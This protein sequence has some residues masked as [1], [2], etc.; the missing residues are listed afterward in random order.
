MRYLFVCFLAL[1]LF[2]SLED[3][4][5]AAPTFFSGVIS[6]NTVWTASSSPYVL[7]GKV[8]IS[9][10]ITLTVEQGA[11]VKL[12]HQGIVVNGSVVV[13]GTEAEPV[14]ITS[15]RDDTAGGDTNNDGSNTLPA[16]ADWQGIQFN[17]GATGTF[18]HAII[19]YAGYGYYSSIPEISTIHNLGAQIT[20][21]QSEL[22]FSRSCGLGQLS[23]VAELS[24][25]RMY[26][27]ACGVGILGGQLTFKNNTIGDSDIGLFSNGAEKIEVIDNTFQN[28]DI[29]A[30]INLHN[31]DFVHSGNTASGFGFNGFFIR[32]E[33]GQDIHLSQNSVPYIITGGGGSSGAGGI[34][35]IRDNNLTVGTTGTLTFGSGVIVKMH[36]SGALNVKGT[37]N[38]EGTSDDPVH[39]TSVKDDTVG[40]DTNGDG[41]A[42]VPASGDWLHIRFESGSSG[43]IDNSIIRYGGHRYPGYVRGDSLSNIFNSGGIIDIDGSDISYGSVYGIRNDNGTTTIH[44]SSIH[45][46]GQF[47]ISNNTTAPLDAINNYWGDPSGPYHEILNPT[48]LGDR[49]TNKVLFEPWKGVYCTENCYSNVLFLPGIKGS[50]LYTGNDNKVWEPLGDHS[51]EQLAMTEAGESIENIYTNDIVSKA[52]GFV[53][54]Y[55]GFARFM[56]RLTDPNQDNLIADWTPFAYDW[57]YGV[58]DVAKNGTQYENEI[59]DLVDEVEHLAI[60]S[61]SGQV[62]IIAHSNGGLLA[63]MLIS[64]LEAEGQSDLIDKVVFLA[65]PQLGTPLAI[66]SIL[67]GYDEEI[68][69]GLIVSDE[70]AREVIKNMPGGYGLLP[71]QKYF[72]EGPGPK[73]LFDDSASTVG[74]RAAYGTSIDNRNELN[75]F[76]LGIGDGRADA[77]TVEEA[78]RANGTM[79]QDSS[80]LH[81]S[82][83]DTRIAP[84]GIEVIEIVGTGLDTISGFRYT[85]FT[86]R[87]C[88]LGV[89]NCEIKAFY[90]PVPL[91]SQYGDGVVIGSSAEGYSG[92][93]ETLY[94]DLE[95]SDAYGAPYDVDHGEITNSPSIQE[96]IRNILTG[97]NNEIQF[98]S[99]TEPGFNTKRIL[100]GAHSPVTINA[101]GDEGV[102]LKIET[103]QE[104]GVPF[105]RNEIPGSSYFEL[106]GSKYLILPMDSDY[107]I[108][109]QGTGEG[110]LVLTMDLLEG[111]TQTTLHTVSVATI[112]AST[113]IDLRYKDEELSNIFVDIN[114]DGTIDQE[115]TP[116]GDIVSNESTYDDLYRA[117]DTLPLKSK[118]KKP[119]IALGSVAEKFNERALKNEK[120]H[121]PESVALNQL[122]NM[123]NLYVRI[124]LLSHKDIEPIILIINDLRSNY[125]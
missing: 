93:K 109:I 102:Q 2:F 64:R 84:D 21:R 89:F 83:L 57:R 65:S 111:E 56:T 78:I 76:M 107:E 119:L 114:G 113:T 77:T 53:D 43:N 16:A 117:V 105:V 69:G 123:L 104:T 29:A 112:T 22:A 15:Q 61:R 75:A 27:M 70:S 54:I 94:I 71:S 3:I 51:V 5:Y 4:T 11:V 34:R 80:A 96:S 58:D 74:F 37:L 18:D 59:R 49:I 125:E 92:G 110:G 99:Q 41:N 98:V 52:H 42:S 103:N 86:E 91:I 72:E 115:I 23:G 26:S 95:A 73:V 14:Y 20:V 28:S 24:H 120:F 108:G 90:K 38:I 1:I 36:D 7:T 35:L 101:V 79:L 32:G 88:L 81:E 40:G 118:S 12:W 46:N 39:F 62:T 66:G 60:G 25:S 9:E 87:V 10:G 106:G 17:A 97:E 6:E 122:E 100:L 82:A 8:T 55:D 31:L 124:K 30:D 44:Q 116:D 45:D 13:T 67:H 33:V 50:R 19:R 63:K 48:G 68:F 85:E 47:G 121:K